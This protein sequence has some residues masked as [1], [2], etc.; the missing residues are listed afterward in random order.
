MIQSTMTASS[1]AVPPSSS[2]MRASLPMDIP[3]ATSRLS[4]SPSPANPLRNRPGDSSSAKR[5]Q[6]PYLL[7]TD[8]SPRGSR[9]ELITRRLQAVPMPGAVRTENLLA[10]VLSPDNQIGT[11]SCRAQPAQAF[12]VKLLRIPRLRAEWNYPHPCHDWPDGL[13]SAGPDRDNRRLLCT[14]GRDQW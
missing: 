14:C 2:P 3:L 8:P 10:C 1:T 12:V 7:L 9:R 6:R 13:E 5:N 4:P 11:I